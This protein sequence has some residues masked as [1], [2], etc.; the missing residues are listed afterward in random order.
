MTGASEILVLVLLISC[1]LI[2][3]RLFRREPAQ[4]KP[5]IS[6]SQ[7]IKNLSM[8]MRAAIFLTV[9]YPCA[10][11]L[12]IKPWESRLPLYILTGILPVVSVWAI[13][14]ILGGRGKK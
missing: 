8:K 13:A 11:A 5:A 2:L 1:I 4:K 12:F 9:T 3:P 7:K 10:A 6:P 14:W